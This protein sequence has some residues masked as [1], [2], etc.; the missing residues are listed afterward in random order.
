MQ[1]LQHEIHNNDLLNFI[2]K[3]LTSLIEIGCSSGALARDFKAIQPKCNYLGV[4]IDYSY[5]QLAKRYCDDYLV[6]DI[7]GAPESF[8]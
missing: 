6:L 7:E 3:H 2:P 1:T 8:F 4:E 5:A